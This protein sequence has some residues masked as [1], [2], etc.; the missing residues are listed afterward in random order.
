LSDE[1]LVFVNRRGVAKSSVNGGSVYNR[2]YWTS[3]NR[4]IRWVGLGNLDLR[5][6][7][8]VKMMDIHDGGPGDVTDEL[9]DFDFQINRHHFERFLDTWGVDISHE[10]IMWILDYLESF[11]CVASHRT[12]S[13]RVAP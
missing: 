9:I 10:S 8:P 7:G 3:R 2:A 11:D 6:G 4:T 5:C 13:G 1:G 12:A